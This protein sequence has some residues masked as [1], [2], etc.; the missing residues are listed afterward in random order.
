MES[1]GLTDFL[2]QVWGLVALTVG[3]G[4]TWMVLMFIIMRRA[5]ERRRRK[6]EGLEP[7][8]SFFTQGWEWLQKQ[9][10]EKPKTPAE[11]MPSPPTTSAAPAVP[12]PDLDMLTSDLPLP[13][14]SN[15]MDELPDHDPIEA[16]IAP[17][18]PEKPVEAKPAA[19]P[20]ASIPVTPPPAAVPPAEE[21]VP[22]QNPNYSMQ[23]N[24]VPG[25]NELPYDAVEVMRVWRDVTDGTL[26]VGMRDKL[27]ATSGELRDPDI[28]RRFAAALRELNA[29]ALAAG[30]SVGSSAPISGQIVS[31]RT[32]APAAPTPAPAAPARGAKKAE[33]AEP[34]P[35]P[36]G[37]ADQIE[38]FLQERLARTPRF[39]NRSIHVY[40]GKSGAVSIEVDGRTFETVHD[41]DDV[42][43]RDFLQATIQEWSEHH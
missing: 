32:T 31:P 37:I 7:L 9:L 20:A 42:A 12:S 36:L 5:A 40:A 39:A 33:P 41:V 4:V 18:Q 26:I 17:R 15:L 14:M 1:G 29:L 22:L 3:A 30:L 27:F 23:M 11:A 34:E 28:A 21:A 25:S 35:A 16:I 24:Y 19:M 10:E 13:D 38:L 6:R 8:P 2:S 43:V